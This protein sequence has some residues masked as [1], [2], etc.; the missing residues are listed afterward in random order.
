M[1]DN[2]IKL[3]LKEIFSSLNA[4]YTFQIAVRPHDPK[5]NELAD[6]LK[7]VA[8]SSENISCR[9]EEGNEPFFKILKNDT[10][11]GILFRAIPGGHEFTSLLLA[12]LN[13]DGKGKN[14]PDKHTE[15]RIKALRGEISLTTFM[16]LECTNC[17]DVVQAL[18]IITLLNPG[19]SHEILD[20]ALH[21]DEVQ[22]Q[23]IQAVPTVF[24]NGELLHIGRGSIGELLNKLEEKF[25]YSETV[26][27]ETKSYDVIVAG[28]G[29]AG[30]TAAI[31]SARKGLK[32]AIVA[33]RI[34]GQVNETVGIENITSIPYTTGKQLAA[35]L[36]KHLHDYPIDIL[37]N[38]RIENINIVDGI[39]IVNVKGGETYTAPVLIAAT[40]ADWRK[41]GIPGEEEYTGRGVAFC[42]HCDGPFYKGK[43]VAVI[44][45]GNS[46]VEAAIDLAG[47]CSKVTLIEY[48]E[49]LK[50]DTI[51]QEKLRS[52]PNVDI[53]TNKAT[54]EIVGNG[55]KVTGIIVK[56]RTDGNENLIALDGVFVQIGLKANSTLFAHLLDTNRIGEIPTDKNCRTAIKGL[57]AA[58]DVSDVSYK[59]I[60][61]SMGEGAKAALAA[62]EDRLRNDIK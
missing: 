15:A 59:Q 21:E 29:P 56:E 45:G 32:T 40:G 31:Y 54:S 1:L 60:I 17:P 22:K 38:R 30:A 11:T 50:A 7:E 33:E 44:G 6:M 25:G 23:N 26:K 9:T 10:P 35:D 28:G 39:K 34:G 57:Y 49:N 37:E 5:S 61:I 8:D 4:H 24:A 36:Y 43:H 62:F 13:A 20:G 2:A 51:L 47:I 27:S 55:N 42:P 41:L 12:I 58:G 46:G 52:L 19:I 53:M 14:L 3:Q 48:L 16:S 18:N